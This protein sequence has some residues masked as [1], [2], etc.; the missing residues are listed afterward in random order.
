MTTPTARLRLW[1]RVILARMACRTNKQAA[2]QCDVAERSIMRWQLE[3][4]FI[5]REG[6]VSEKVFEGTFNQL[7]SIGPDGVEALRRVAVDKEAPAGAV[8]SA[9]RA[10]L[11]VQLRAQEVL[12]FGRR[13][14]ELEKMIATEG[15]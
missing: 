2:E 9:G 3:P 5:K 10:I 1:D 7:R 15:E 12:N 13:L 4:E 14:S 6:E 8:V 11:E